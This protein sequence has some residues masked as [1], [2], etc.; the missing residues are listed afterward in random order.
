VRQAGVR[1]GNVVA[2]N[3]QEKTIEHGMQ[4]VVFGQMIA[5]ADEHE[6]GEPARLLAAAGEA[7][8]QWKSTHT[9]GAPLTGRNPRIK[10]QPIVV[11][12]DSEASNAKNVSGLA[13]M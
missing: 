13:P 2:M 10:L 1:R 7:P 12:L 6:R 5:G 11:A 3:T 4:G 9:A 8:N